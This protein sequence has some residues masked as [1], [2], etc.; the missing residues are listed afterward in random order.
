MGHT[1]RNVRLPHTYEILGGIVG[2][3]TTLLAAKHVRLLGRIVVSRIVERVLALPM[4]EVD[5]RESQ[6]RN[7]LRDD[8]QCGKSSR[9]RDDEVRASHCV[10]GGSTAEA[11]GLRILRM[12][13]HVI[14]SYEWSGGGMSWRF[15]YRHGAARDTTKVTAGQLLV[16]SWLD[17]WMLYRVRSGACTGGGA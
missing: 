1:P 16:S 12:G 17:A 8:D 4:P 11:C 3:F 14:I 13:S 5:G 6:A 7:E 10:Y 9:Q 2:S 15:Q